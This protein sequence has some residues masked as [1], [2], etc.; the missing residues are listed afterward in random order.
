MVSTLVRARS[1][2][3]GAARA[4]EQQRL[5]GPILAEIDRGIAALDPLHTASAPLTSLDNTVPAPEQDVEALRREV[6]RLRALVRSDRGLL[7]TVLNYSPHGILVSDPQGKI[8]LQNRAAERIWAGSATTE[9]VE[10]WGQYRA[11]HDDGR[12]YDPGDWAMARA[13]SNGGVVDAEEVHFQRFDGTHGIL[14]GSAA[15]V[16]APDGSISG[17]VSTFADIT[18]FKQ[19]ERDLRLRE[20]W[21]STTLR[22][23]AD[24]VIATDDT[25]RV[26]FMNAVAERLTGAS[27]QEAKGRN[28]EDLLLV[29]DEQSRARV[30]DLAR[31]VLRDGTAAELSNA[32]LLRKDG[33]VTIDES[34][35]PLRN[36]AGDVLGVVL[37]L[38]DVTER[39]RAE[40]RRHFIGEASWRL[41]SSALDYDGTLTSVAGLG[42]PRVADWCLVDIAEADGSLV[43]AAVAHVDPARA[44]MA[45][46]LELQRQPASTCC[47]QAIARV[48]RGD[49]SGYTAE[50]IGHMMAATSDDR[51]YATILGALRDEAA[52]CVPLRARDRVLGAMTFVCAE[53][54]RTF[55]PEDAALA[56]QLASSAALAIDNARL[57]REAQRVN[58]VKDE[59]LATLSHELRTPLNAILGW[60]RLLRMGKLDEA[61]RGRALETIERN[62]EAQAQLIEDLLDVS[63]IISGKFRVDVRTVD[64]P[65]V[66][67]AAI[68]A[69]RLAA[70]AKAIAIVAQ[71]DPVPLLAGDPTRLQQVV[72]NLL[73]N[74][75]KF[76]SKG[77]RVHV[78][79]ACVESHVE[80]EIVD[81]GQGIRAD[82]LPYVFDRFRQA[83]GTTTRA[84]AGLGLGLAIVRHLV[85]LHG[86]SVRAHSDG[87]GHGAVF[88]VRLPVAAVRPK[89]EGESKH[90]SVLDDAGILP[91]RG[92]RVLVVDDEVD[93]RELVAAVLTESGAEVTAVG[94]VPEALEMVQISRPDVLVSDIGMPAEDGYSLIRKVR[95]MEKSLGR[96]PAAALTAYASVQD[97]TRALLAGY[98][99]HLPKPIEPAELTAVVAN[100]AGRPARG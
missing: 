44:V 89:P 23:I 57:Y 41:A 86:G 9:N 71:I 73:S 38:R 11:F 90:E 75:I 55:G 64:M 49:S 13:L 18:R 2:V 99:S 21:L 10:G 91:L 53:S 63:R 62:A 46:R 67:E 74:A 88:S 77:G 69:V 24:G 39:R 36:E 52:I 72:W 3:A 92:L 15:P 93:A 82:F 60:A 22:S 80:L 14:L 47:G 76:T 83:D 33:E 12:P 5:I 19:L 31:L 81:N 20:A 28:I 48:I 4:P 97:R 27:M 34:A 29:V 94:S 25:G 65:A 98:S 30:D 50:V 66:T 78:K 8:T 54:G 7:E 26:E 59:F 95:A 85:E 70:E 16:Y 40:A 17:A 100:L 32:L 35:A 1:S 58:R 79:L 56:Q 84:H 42:V 45:G 68:D 87:E 51:A 37:V 6:E 61:A 96:I 43:R